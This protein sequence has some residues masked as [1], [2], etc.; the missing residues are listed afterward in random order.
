MY[1]KEQWSA[2]T[3]DSVATAHQ[4]VHLIWTQ[5]HAL[6]QRPLQWKDVSGNF[7]RG[8]VKGKIYPLNSPIS[9]MALYDSQNARSKN[10]RWMNGSFYPVCL[11]GTPIT[12]KISSLQAL[13]DPGEGQINA[14]TQ[15]E[16]EVHF[17][18]PFFYLNHKNYRRRQDQSVC[19]AGFAYVLRRA[20]SSTF[21]IDKGPLITRERERRLAQDSSAEV[22]HIRLNISMQGA[23]IFLPI[24]DS[25][26]YTVRTQIQA[27]SQF[28]VMGIRFYRIEGA[29]LRGDQQE[30]LIPI[31]ASAWSNHGYV[32]QVGDDVEAVIWLQ[33]YLEKMVL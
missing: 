5:G 17:F 25:P 10:A 18:D 2:L 30:L 3:G 21:Q 31:Y 20:K 13:A 12:L 32:P 1:F 23:S 33:G 4:A 8:H 15:D 22:S 28:E 29:L 6:E 26:D 7:C 27:V 24:H 9:F 11:Q 19:L 16:S 14:L